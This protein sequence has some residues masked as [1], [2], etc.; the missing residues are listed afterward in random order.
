MI[1]FSYILRGVTK[2]SG[3]GVKK[4]N[5]F[6]NIG[7]TAT[8]YVLNQWKLNKSFAE[9]STLR[10]HE[11]TH[12]ERNFRCD[13]CSKAFVRKDYL[14]K[15]SLTHRQTFK[16]SQCSYVCHIKVDIERH[17]TSMHSS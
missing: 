3:P 10:K 15:H 12:G 8:Y 17:V 2:S 16:C 13:I 7:P 14:A 5:V 9:L 1:T 4:A 11:A 6:A